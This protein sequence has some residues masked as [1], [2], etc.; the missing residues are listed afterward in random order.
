MSAAASSTS[1]SA[2]HLRTAA[3][4]AGR[5]SRNRP[6]STSAAATERPGTPESESGAV[7]DPTRRGPGGATDAWTRCSMPSSNGRYTTGATAL[8]HPSASAGGGSGRHSP[9]REGSSE[10]TTVAPTLQPPAST[11]LRVTSS[12]GRMANGRGGRNADANRAQFGRRGASLAERGRTST[13]QACPSGHPSAANNSTGECAITCFVRPRHNASAAAE[14]GSR[15]SSS[16]HGCGGMASSVGGGGG[17]RKK[18]AMRQPRKTLP[19]RRRGI[20]PANSVHRIDGWAREGRCFRRGAAISCPKPAGEAGEW[21][22]TDIRCLTPSAA[23]SRSPSMTAEWLPHTW[24]VIYACTP[25]PEQTGT[26]KRERFV[27]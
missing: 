27:M 4:P 21:R 1:A 2:R 22:P 14:G 16:G 15:Y 7:R 12:T 26:T 25:V 24:V 9:R 8:S 11:A 6:W 19:M 17:D 20:D 5:R 23:S 13:G 10:P 18:P 3:T